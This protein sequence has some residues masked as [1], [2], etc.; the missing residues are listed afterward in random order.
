MDK[1]YCLLT[2]EFLTFIV[3]RLI[4]NIEAK[5]A[6]SESAIKQFGH[7]RNL[8]GNVQFSNRLA[9]YSPLSRSRFSLKK[10]LIHL[11]LP[12]LQSKSLANNKKKLNQQSIKIYRNTRAKQQSSNRFL[13]GTFYASLCWF[14][15]FAFAG[16]VLLVFFVPK[17]VLFFIFLSPIVKRK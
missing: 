11:F 2:I 16:S 12:I 15:F 7:R 14:L 17:K 1:I 6:A 3:I 10:L 8:H 5:L 4:K 13:S 9:S